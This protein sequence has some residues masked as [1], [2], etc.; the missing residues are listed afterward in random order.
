MEMEMEKN[1]CHTVY[2]NHPTMKI[3]ALKIIV[4]LVLL[5]VCVVL[6]KKFLS[7]KKRKYN[8]VSNVQL[9]LLV[10]S[11][12][13]FLLALDVARDLFV[14]A[15]FD[16]GYD[17]FLTDYYVEEYSPLRR[18]LR[19]YERISNWFERTVLGHEFVY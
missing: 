3:N 1:L 5:V 15:T 18:K 19:W 10:C 17:P 2:Y 13:T 6:T 8:T 7:E 14:P 9:T 11:C 12:I 16:G 4:L